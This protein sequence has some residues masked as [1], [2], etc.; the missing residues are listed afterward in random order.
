[1]FRP[2]MTET[3]D[4]LNVAFTEVVPTTTET[5]VVVNLV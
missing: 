4:W 5:V 1:M 2:D 3:V